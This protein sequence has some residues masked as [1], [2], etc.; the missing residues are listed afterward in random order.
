MHK[1]VVVEQATL[2]MDAGSEKEVETESNQALWCS[3]PRNICQE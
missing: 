2:V 3:L 1:S